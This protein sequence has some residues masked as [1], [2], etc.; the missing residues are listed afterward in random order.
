M[1]FDASCSKTVVTGPIS[2]YDSVFFTLFDSGANHS[3]VSMKIVDRL[4]RPSSD[5][6]R[7]FHIL[8]S[9][10]EL[11]VSRREIRALPIVIEGRELHVDLVELV[12][13]DFDFILGM[14]MLLKY[15]GN[16]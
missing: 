9:N 5:L 14:D 10:G 1:E 2:S 6:D 7:G 12:I 13:E 16:D 4:C 3:F 8:L 11:I 15:G